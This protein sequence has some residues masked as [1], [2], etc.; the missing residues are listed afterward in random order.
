M[1][2]DFADPATPAQFEADV[3]IAGSGPA[4]I[5]LA[6]SLA[7]A[8]HRVLMLEAGNIHFE[9]ESQELYK[10]RNLGWDYP[11]QWSRLRQFGGTMGHWTGQCGL[12]RPDDLAGGPA[13]MAW[14]VPYAALARWH[15]EASRFLEVNEEP[16]AEVLSRV[17]TYAGARLLNHAWRF[18]THVPLRL[19]EREEPVMRAHRTI[20]LVLH[21]AVTGVTGVG[22]DGMVEGFRFRTLAGRVG[23][24]RGRLLV[25]ACGGIENARLLQVMHRGGLPIVPG[26]AAHLGLYMQ[27]HPNATVGRLA[28]THEGYQIMRFA[29][30]W[31]RGRGGT[32]L[33]AVSTPFDVQTRS[34]A[35]GCYFRFGRIGPKMDRTPVE[36]PP[37]GPL[38]QRL[39][40]YARHFDEISHAKLVRRFPRLFRTD[41][42]RP[43]S[44][45]VEMEQVP[46]PRNRVALGREVDAIGLP[47]VEV[48]MQ[49]REAEIVTMRAAI[50]H[51]A[52][53]VIA[54]GLGRV[55]LHPWTRDPLAARVEWDWSWH[56]NGTTRMAH[57][58]ADGVVDPDQLVFGTRNLHVAG[59][60]VFPTSGFVNP[61]LTI[62]AMS[63]RLGEILKDRLRG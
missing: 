41:T 13:R 19:G 7:G 48:D 55:A 47:V 10:G 61:T 16:D 52:R 17:P 34:G 2:L 53:A 59:A 1:I 46:D 20:G 36:T 28:A 23:E 21:A 26:A 37:V 38:E 31:V 18:S 43:F 40:H 8:G 62:V 5:S 57:R 6:K 29:N 35:G 33:P 27:E 22:P 49:V 4:A 3:V 54:D 39:Q 25:L 12:L 32:W 58:P 44:L 30:T 24:A 50:D 15:L 42:V 60:S 11:I 56:H 63:L 45:F 14:P 51:L 9:E